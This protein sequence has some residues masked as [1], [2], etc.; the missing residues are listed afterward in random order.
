MSAPS[1]NF[2]VRTASYRQKSDLPLMGRSLSSKLKPKDALSAPISPSPTLLPSPLTIKPPPKK[3]FLMR[4]PTCV[5]TLLVILMLH[6]VVSSA[7]IFYASFVYFEG[8]GLT[9]SGTL[10]LDGKKIDLGSGHIM[11]SSFKQSDSSGIFISSD[12]VS[13]KS[14]VV[15][16]DGSL[17][18]GE[19]NALVTNTFE[20]ESGN[21]LT[22][23]SD[24][25]VYSEATFYAQK[26]GSTTASLLHI[27]SGSQY[28][29]LDDANN[30]LLVHSGKIKS[31]STMRLESTSS[32][33]ELAAFAGNIVAESAIVGSSTIT[34]ESGFVGPSVFGQSGTG[35]SLG[36]GTSTILSLNGTTKSVSISVGSSLEVSSISHPQPGGDLKVKSGRLS[37]NDV[38]AL[39]SNGVVGLD[40]DLTLCTKN[41]SNCFVNLQ[42]ASRKVEV[43]SSALLTVDRIAPTSSGRTRVAFTSSGVEASGVYG[44]SSL[45]LGAGS[46]TGVVAI[47]DASGGRTSLLGSLVVSTITSDVALTVVKGTTFSS[48]ITLAA[49]KDLTFGSGHS[50]KQSVTGLQVVISGKTVTSF[51]SDKLSTTLKIQT[52]RIATASSSDKL[53]L[54]VGGLTSVRDLG[55]YINGTTRVAMF[56]NSSL[57][58]DEEIKVNRISTYSN[59]KVLMESDLELG[60]SSTS[61]SREIIFPRFSY[62][63]LAYHDSTVDGCSSNEHYGRLMLLTTSPTTSFL[64]VCIRTTSVNGWRCSGLNPP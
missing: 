30:Q 35:L 40:G 58:V 11:A 34:A 46:N 3:P 7:V 49:N 29:K 8:K 25:G 18:L 54:D 5:M 22:L 39:E 53:T 60:D 51:E 50:L 63:H 12:E 37:L 59:G 56:R 38:I 2:H 10:F 16:I 24:V 47:T 13:L 36:V 17:K 4:H 64:C 15:A 32:N 41:T 23:R 20:A 62:P 28:M 57:E 26:Y 42:D 14:S 27:A 1:P 9:S 19:G 6:V 44:V 52:P 43:V 21:P 45:Q 48:G 61:N 33:L 31:T 55:I